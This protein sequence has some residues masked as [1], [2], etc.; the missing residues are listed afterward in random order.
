MQFRSAARKFL[1][2]SERFSLEVRKGQKNF[3]LIKQL[4]SSKTS[5]GLIE[6][7]LDNPA[8]VFSKTIKIVSIQN[9]KLIR[10][11]YEVFQKNFSSKKSFYGHVE[12]SFDNPA[13]KFWTKSPEKFGFKSE[14]DWKMTPFFERSFFFQNGPRVS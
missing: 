1:R 12:C 10:K 2:T 14:N 11:S 9:W 3:S 4:F 7:K 6:G 8:D 13:E 5:F